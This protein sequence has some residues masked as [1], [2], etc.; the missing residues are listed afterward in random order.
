MAAAPSSLQQIRDRLLQAIDSQSNNQNIVVVL[1]IISSLEKYPITKEALEETRLGKLINDLRKKTKNEGL[2]KRAKKLL[3]N[4]QKLIEP[5]NSSLS[6]SI[7]IGGSPESF[8][9][10]LGQLQDLGPESSCSKQ[11]RNDK[12]GIMIPINSV[13]SHTSSPG[14]GKPS[15]PCVQSKA[16]VQQQL[17][18]ADQTSG[19][20]HPKGP[21]RSSFSPRNSRHKGSFARQRSPY[22]P[23]GSVPSPL[24]RPQ[25]LDVTQVPSPL[26]LA[27][28]C[29]HP[30]RRPELLPSAES[31]VHWLEQPEGHQRL[32]G[33]VCK[34]GLSPAESILPRAGFSP[35]SSRADS[36]AASSGGSG[37]KRKRSQPRDYTVNLGGQVAEAGVKPVR[38][39][40]R[41]L[42]L[43]PMTRQIKPLTQK[44]PVRADSP[45]HTEQPRTGL[46]KPEA[47]T[48]LQSPFE[49]MNRM[50]LSRN[51][52]IQSHLSPQ[53]SLL[54]SSSAQ[55]PGAHHFMSEFLKQK[56]STQRGARTPQ[57][58][59]PPGPSTD[60][61]ELSR[62]VTQNDL[63][64]IHAHRWPGVNECLDTLGNWYDWTQCISLDP[65]GDGGRLNILPYVCLD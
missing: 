45:V 13:R 28:P 41:K 20:P 23:K 62:Q 30:V 11:V 19:P 6:P 26:P 59:L 64:R 63:D 55:T 9:G 34:A 54:S 21:P 8:P 50:E 48:S 56:E 35:D 60:L 3:R 40:E 12:Q 18:R 58:L 5:S 53:S 17:E 47:K 7:E 1:E 52:I 2:A 25:S 61:P 37:R 38:L 49:Q 65:H 36:D 42:T 16:A 4:W 46:D 22:S 15:R 43:D 27:Q 44:E 24:P 29:T 39:K 51:E 14:L 33:P 32:A 31:P 57:V 10:P